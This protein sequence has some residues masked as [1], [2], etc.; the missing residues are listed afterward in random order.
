M[1]KQHIEVNTSS[2]KAS[3]VLLRL[4]SSNLVEGM[5]KG[6]SAT[7]AMEK[8]E[9]AKCRSIKAMQQKQHMRNQHLLCGYKC[10]NKLVLNIV[11]FLRMRTEKSYIICFKK[12]VSHGNHSFQLFLEFLLVGTFQLLSCYI[13]VKHKSFQFKKK[14]LLNF[15]KYM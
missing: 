12:S 15:T 5:H 8:R 13:S 10:F 1:T 11:Q 14:K 6:R 4:P 7:A 3:R 2:V 9:T